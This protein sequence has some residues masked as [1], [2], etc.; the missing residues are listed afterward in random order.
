[1]FL[2]SAADDQSV[3]LYRVLGT[4]IG[5]EADASLVCEIPAEGASSMRCLTFVGDN[6][7]GGGKSCHCDCACPCRSVE[8]RLLAQGTWAGLWCGRSHGLGTTRI[9]T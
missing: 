2:A 6:L 7:V 9:A 5:G 3:R 1:M 8:C 4:G